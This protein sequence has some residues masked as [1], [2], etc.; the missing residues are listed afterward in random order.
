MI[1][2]FFKTLNK[3]RIIF[4]KKLLHILTVIML[5]IVYFSA[6]GVVSLINF[7]LRKDLLDKKFFDKS[8]FWLDKEHIASDFERCKR[9]F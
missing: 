4:I 2:E 7:I 9:Q 1:K 8:S 3:Y 5:S 6:L